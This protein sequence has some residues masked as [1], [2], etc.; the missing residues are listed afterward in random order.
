MRDQLVNYCYLMRWVTVHT[1]W[2]VFFSL[3]KVGLNVLNVCMRWV[4]FNIFW[5]LGQNSANLDAI[6]TP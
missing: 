6:K 5:F 1:A 3:E 2:E 4:K